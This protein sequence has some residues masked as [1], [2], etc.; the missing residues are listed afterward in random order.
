VLAQLVELQFERSIADFKQS[1][2]L[3]RG[4]S[5]LIFPASSEEIF[6]LDFFGTTLEG[7]RVLQPITNRVLE[8]VTGIDIFPAKHFMTSRSFEGD[9]VP[10]IRAE[11]DERI[12]F[13][14]SQGKLVEAERIKT[15]TEYDIE[16]MLETGYVGGIEN[17]SMYLAG[18]NPGETPSTLI[19]FF[20]K[21]FITFV[22][23]SHISLPQ[24]GGMYAG[25]RARKENLIQYG[26]RLPSAFENRPLQFDEFE[27]KLNTTVYVSATPGP[28]E[29][30]NAERVHEQIIRPTGLIDPYIF[31]EEMEF[32]VDS[33]LAEIQA[34]C[35]RNERA[36]LTTLTKKSS[37]DL[38]NF[39]AGN[40]IKVQYLHSEIET[41][42]RLEILRNLRL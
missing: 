38:A 25:D 30:K 23:E 3:L 14:Q 35:E 41:I 10:R 31:I 4:D 7:I 18:R 26:F 21:D 22:D 15:K 8:T 1:M 36:L 27:K 12:A 16:M 13:F 6:A 29:Q 42:E 40:G 5:L 9:I 24:V 17:Y 2:F 20:P 32:C 28:Y 39:L 33:I 34:A 19:D 11:L 37:E